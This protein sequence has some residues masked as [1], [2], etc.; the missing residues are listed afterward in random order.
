VN[1][2]GSTEGQFSAI[3]QQQQ[4]QTLQQALGFAFADP[5]NQSQ[6]TSSSTTGGFGTVLSNLMQAGGLA[7]G[8]ATGGG[9]GGLS[10]L[11]GGG[12]GSG[13]GGAET[14]GNWYSGMG[15]GPN[16]GSGEGI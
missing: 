7:F 14:N 8:L 5:G 11:F 2:V 4:N 10:G 9:G 13:E 6:G 3:A 12:G 1:A 16:E 15:Q